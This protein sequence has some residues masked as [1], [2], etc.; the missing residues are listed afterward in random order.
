MAAGNPACH[1]SGIDVTIQNNS[2]TPLRNVEVD[3]PGAAF[4]AGTIAPG[5]SYWY[6][7]KPTENGEIT[8][9]FEQANGNVFRQKGPQVHAGNR[10]KLILIVDQDALKRWRVNA[11]RSR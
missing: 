8:I 6:H 7:I 9:S 5:R 10:E 4:G 2:S 1:A 3:Y 11:Q